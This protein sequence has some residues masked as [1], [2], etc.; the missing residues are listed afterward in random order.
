MRIVCDSC[1][2][3]YQIADAKIAGKLFRVRCKKCSNMIMVD[4]TQLGGP[5]AAAAG[6]GASDAGQAVWYVVIDGAQTGPLNEEELVAQ[7]AQGLIDSD[8]Y[9]WKEGMADWLRMSDV[10]AL[11]H[12][13]P[14]NDGFGGEATQVVSS[15]ERPVAGGVVSSSGAF[16]VDKLIDSSLGSAVNEPIVPASPF[17]PSPMS[18]AVA[19]RVSGSG[20]LA[21]AAADSARSPLTGSSAPRAAA[22]AEDNGGFTAERNESSVLFSLSDLTAPKSQPR[23]GDAVPRTEGSGL[24]DIR[25]LASAQA[26]LA[27]PTESDAGVAGP[28]AILAPAPTMAPMALPP[29]R[30]SMTPYIALGALMVVIV[31][32]LVM[33]LMNGDE[34]VAVV[35]A[36]PTTQDDG[37]ASRTAASVVA[38]EDEAAEAPVADGE[39]EEA[40]AVA[41]VDEGTGQADA[42][43]TGDPAVVALEGEAPSEEEIAASTA[44]DAAAEPA[45]RTRVERA[46]PAREERRTERGSVPERER[47]REPEPEREEPRERVAEPPE[48]EPTVPTLRREDSRDSD[49]VAAALAAIQGS[50][51]APATPASTERP[52]AEV[53][54]AEPAAPAAPATLG[55]SEVQSAV[56]RYNSRVARC[57]EYG[58]PGTY[59][60]TFS[61][62]RDGSVSGVS[63]E[64][65]NDVSNCVAGVVRAMTF[66][67][68]TG[69]PIPVTYPF[70]LN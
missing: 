22:T 12:L 2:A 35:T 14:A 26:A 61:I 27:P 39:P 50:N 63:P 21:A 3:K 4:G 30:Q 20:L 23:G 46:E 29:R 60:V 58:E 57:T 11:A 6:V 31:L 13:V 19:E 64:N 68:F 42:E 51:S 55:R 10:P 66:P 67:R 37:V 38:A 54:E 48:P 16:A 43:G 65:S 5:V 36:E 69:D 24:I 59:R 53:A 34:P 49:A 40:P 1:S 47:E 52:A 17:S 33:L 7:I 32:L 56:R 70:R 9:A 15:E 18:P 45:S 41:L 8:T 25:T 28:G 44:A 62:Q